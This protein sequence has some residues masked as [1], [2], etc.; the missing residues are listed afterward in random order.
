[1]RLA[2][3]LSNYFRGKT[4]LFEEKVLNVHEPTCW[5]NGCLSKRILIAFTQ[6]CNL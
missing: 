1:M 5:C 6:R 4:K 2:F 3:A